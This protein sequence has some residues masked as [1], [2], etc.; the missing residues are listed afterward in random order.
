MDHQ[1]LDDTFY[2]E[3][4][5]V[6]INKEIYQVQSIEFE[7]ETFFFVT[8]SDEV[9]CMIMQDEKDEWKPDCI[10]NQELSNKL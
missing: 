4:N 2:G 8:R 7:D 9:I 10:I 1:E 5:T 3:V 6:Q